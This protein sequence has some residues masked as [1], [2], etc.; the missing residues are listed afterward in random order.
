MRT[1]EAELQQAQ[2]DLSYCTLVA[3]ADGYVSQKNVEVGEYVQRQK[4]LM[5]IVALGDTWI[6]ARFRETDTDRIEAGQQVTL[7]LDAYPEQKCTGVIES[8]V[9]GTQDSI[10]LFAQYIGSS[11]TGYFSWLMQR[12]PVKIRVPDYSFDP[13][14]PW[15]LGLNT[16]VIVDH[17]KPS[18][19]FFN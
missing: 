6:V 4:P 16:N 12:V 9:S 15:R 7:V 10:G 17:P 1:A 14:S 3:P 5:A 8:V 11:G 18:H 13:Q 2:I 19:K